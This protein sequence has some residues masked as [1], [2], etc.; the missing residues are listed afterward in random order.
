[1][2]EIATSGTFASPAGVQIR[3]R[4]NAAA[5]VDPFRCGFFWMSGL[6][7]E[8]AG[9]KAEAVAKTSVANGRRTFRFDYSGH[10][11]SGGDFFDGTISRWLEEARLAFG[12]ADG[13]RVVVGSSM[14]AWIALLLLRLLQNEGGLGDVRVRGLVLIAPAGDMTDRLMW[15][16]FSDDQ[17]AQL[18]TLGYVDLPS[19][20]G[21]PY[22]ITRELI[23]DGWRHLVMN[24]PIR[25]NCPVRILQGTR[26]PDL[27]PYHAVDLMERIHGPDTALVM[28]RDG[29][30]RLSRQT[31]I[32]LLTDVC[33]DLAVLADQDDTFSIAMSASSPSR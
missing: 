10:G 21:P 1:M 20:Y 23:A 3:W 19:L 32:R 15:R 25:V 28:I 27:P 29:D 6:R 13:P 12:L 24:G 31:D 14:G 11:E 26:D 18:E 30:H 16:H 22:R 33:E 17:R 7:S 2:H 9:A 5:G 8:M 4:S